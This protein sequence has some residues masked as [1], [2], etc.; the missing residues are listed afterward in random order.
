M[1]KNKICNVQTGS[2]SNPTLGPGFCLP[3]STITKIQL[4]CSSRTVSGVKSPEKENV[5]IQKSKGKVNHNFVNN[6]FTDYPIHAHLTG[7]SLINIQ[8]YTEA[9]AEKADFNV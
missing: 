1:R 8:Q 7:V 9:P 5:N 6:E 3:C 2:T 4:V